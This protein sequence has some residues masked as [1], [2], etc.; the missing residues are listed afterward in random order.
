M[1][2]KR[3]TGGGQFPL[4]PDVVQ[5]DLI[6]STLIQVSRD[7]TGNH[8]SAATSPQKAPPAPARY[9][10]DLGSGVAATLKGRSTILMTLREMIE[11][12]GPPLARSSIM[13]VAV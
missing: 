13:V 7:A 2:A 4:L 1:A 10:P 3:R 5:R 8:V 12:N 11:G 6:W 9:S